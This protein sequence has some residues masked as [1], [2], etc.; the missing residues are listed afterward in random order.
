MQWVPSALDTGAVD[1][2]SFLPDKYSRYFL[3][4]K[5]GMGLPEIAGELEIPL[6]ALPAFIELAHAKLANEPD[7]LLP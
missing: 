7:D 6:E 1:E 4:R 3:L 2:L 5:A